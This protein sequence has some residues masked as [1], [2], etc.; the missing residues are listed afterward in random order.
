MEYKS[1]YGP[2]SLT[3]HVSRKYNKKVY[4]FG[5]FHSSK[6]HCK[7]PGGSIA[8]D[9]FVQK[10]LSYNKDKIIDIYTEEEFIK[11]SIYKTRKRSGW[12]RNRGSSALDKMT[13]TFKDCL[14]V[15]KKHCKDKNVRIHYTDI[16]SIGNILSLKFGHWNIADMLSILVKVWDN[17]KEFISMK[18]KIERSDF[19][20]YLKFDQ[21]FDTLKITKQLNK[22]PDTQL[23]K[24]IQK[25]FV[26]KL[27]EK[28]FKNLD[29]RVKELYKYIYEQIK[30]DNYPL[31]EI[32]DLRKI[33]KHLFQYNNLLMDF[34][35]IGRM[36]KRFDDQLHPYAENVMILAGDAHCK[37]YRELLK[38]LGFR[39]MKSSYSTKEENCIDISG[40]KQPF[41]S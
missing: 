7:K 39:K 29:K 6:Y 22:N 17:K 35:L 10:T 16:R 1:I 8:F 23:R 20:E 28:V 5:E 4:I 25:F 36:F 13:K 34:Y 2:I 32:K 30:M 31:E 40:F 14:T 12:A 9:K 3:Y 24:K 27:S 26:K 18:H 38:Y 15:S 21:I 11:K 37:T 33:F 19:N 41:F